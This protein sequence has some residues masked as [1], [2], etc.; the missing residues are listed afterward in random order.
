MMNGEV[1]PLPPN[2]LNVDKFCIWAIKNGLL[3][4]KCPSAR[5][6]HE[7]GTHKWWIIRDYSCGKTTPE[8]YMMFININTDKPQLSV[9]NTAI[10]AWNPKPFSW[11]VW[12]KIWRMIKRINYP[13]IGDN[14][15]VIPT[16]PGFIQ[17]TA[18]ITIKQLT[19]TVYPAQIS[20]CIWN[21][22]EAKK[23]VLVAQGETRYV[24]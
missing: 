8:I 24:G 19:P 15:Q 3:Q 7:M 11:G 16:N 18:G 6:M 23:W 4:K 1:I 22:L 2:H 14:L 10:V 20:R 21:E 12:E 9:Y 5:A 13:K 17:G